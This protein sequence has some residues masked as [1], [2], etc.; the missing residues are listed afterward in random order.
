MSRSGFWIV[1]HVD[2]FSIAEKTVWLFIIW[3]LYLVHVYSTITK[4]QCHNACV[5]Y[6]VVICVIIKV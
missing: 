2:Y 4:Q 1:S 6:I 3:N 5:I